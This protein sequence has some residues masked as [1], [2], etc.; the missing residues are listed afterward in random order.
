MIGEKSPKPKS[1]I[2]LTPFWKCSVT[3]IKTQKSRQPLTFRLL[4]IPITQVWNKDTCQ[5]ITNE[6]Q[7]I[8]DQSDATR[9]LCAVAEQDV[10]F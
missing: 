6:R 3:K 10:E 5:T 9:Q 8:V 7:E 1:S 4:F 2:S